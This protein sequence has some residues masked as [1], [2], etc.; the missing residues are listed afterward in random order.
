MKAKDISCNAEW[1][2]C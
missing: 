1:F 2:S